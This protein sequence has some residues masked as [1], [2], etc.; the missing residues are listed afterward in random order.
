MYHSVSSVIYCFHRIGIKQ[1]FPRS[2]CVSLA[3]RFHALTVFRIVDD[4]PV[5][6]LPRRS[7]GDA[8]ITHACVDGT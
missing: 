6:C 1:F 3:F 8:I 4:S 7:A 2:F 5:F